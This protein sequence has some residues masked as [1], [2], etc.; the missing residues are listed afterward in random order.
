MEYRD[1]TPSEISDEVIRRKMLDSEDGASLPAERELG[2]QLGI[3]RTTLRSSL[4]KL[5]SEGEVVSRARGS[6]VNKK[7][8]LNM[9]AMQSMTQELQDEGKEI[10]VRTLSS[11]R[12]A[13]TKHVRDFFHL[14]D[15]DQLFELQRSRVVN[16]AAFTYE[17]TYLKLSRFPHIES[18]DLNN[19][20]LYKTLADQY[21]I[22]PNYGREEVSAILSTDEI[23]AV[24]GIEVGTPLFKVRSLTYDENDE[25]FEYSTQFLVGS[26]AR[27]VLSASNIFDYQEDEEE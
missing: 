23:S 6:Y 5:K 7:M 4:T 21:G 9:L 22:H 15:K 14:K 27:Y 2:S 13:G 3:S 11:K 10:L 19:V 17:V 26:D 16:G 20:S 25:P 1:L 18:L 8:N 12:V 24:L